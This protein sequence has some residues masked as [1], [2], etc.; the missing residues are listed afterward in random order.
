MPI[1]PRQTKQKQAIRDSFTAA[2]RPLSPEEVLTL[3]KSNVPGL[4]IATIYRNI[5]S[6][7]DEGWLTAVAL[8]GAPARYEIAGKQHHHHFQCRDCERVFE[9]SGCDFA[10]KPELPKGFRM[11]GHEFF[12]YGVCADCS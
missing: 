7:V 6:L 12:L 1:T 10:V 5:G 8:P 11:T 4:S 3:S 2:D 9:L